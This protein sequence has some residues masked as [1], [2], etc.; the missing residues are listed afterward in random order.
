MPSCYIGGPPKAP[1]MTQGSAF[2]PPPPPVLSPHARVAALALVYGL[3]VPLLKLLEALGQW[4]RLYGRQIVKLTG[5]FDEYRPTRHDVFACAYFKSGTT[6]LL[7]IGTQIAHRGK[8]EF[9][10]VH[11]LVPWPD[12]PAPMGPHLIPLS[13][14]SPQALSPTGL[15][16]IKTHLPLDRVPFAAQARYI[17][18]VRDPKDV[19]VSG[20]HF[21]RSLI[22]GP[23]M[24]SV[25]HWAELFLTED[26]PAGSWAA[27]L[28]SYW[29]RRTE[30]NVL[31]LTFEAMKW[32]H[33]V[34]IEQIARFMD[35]D[36]SQGELDA[37]EQQSSFAYMKRN[38]AKFSAGQVLLWKAPEAGMLRRGNHG[39][40]GELLTPALQQ[41][42]DDHFRAELRRLGCDFP[43]DEAFA[44]GQPWGAPT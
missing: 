2:T 10:N 17:A 18:L 3:A 25:E 23:M 4:P 41:R 22:L 33:R 24:P 8:A 11:H 31:F 19:I 30:P 12:A 16:L 15:R 28:D 6:W 35:V 40:S 26:S 5:G 13:N 38:E 43:Y 9:D 32:D 21:V 36:L 34:A 7:Q 42:V 20:Y 29:R 14:K 27:H 39:G 44:A 37:V 1:S